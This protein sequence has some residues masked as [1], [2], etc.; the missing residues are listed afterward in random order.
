MPSNFFIIHAG[1]IFI[2]SS[3]HIS[4]TWEAAIEY[5]F[6]KH[7]GSRLLEVHT[8]EQKNELDMILSTI[9]KN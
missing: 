9:H 4:L 1:C 2:D 6:L 3:A 8:E 5:C 7:P